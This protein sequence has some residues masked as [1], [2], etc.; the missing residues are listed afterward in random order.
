[1]NLIETGSPELPRAFSGA[2]KPR[3]PQTTRWAGCE[4]KLEL[5]QGDL[6][7]ESTDAIVNPVG[8]GL[9]D[10]AVRKAAG[11]E[12]LDAYHQAAA[13]LPAGRLLPGQS[14]LTPGFGLCA[15]HVIHTR[16]PVYA[17]DPARA[18]RELAAGY[19]SALRLG[20]THGFESI[21]FPAIATGVYRY[22]LGEAA[23]VAL[24]ALLAALREGAAPRTV[25]FVLSRRAALDAF[26]EAARRHLGGRLVSGERGPTFTGLHAA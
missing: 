5:V 21:A 7:H 23:D 17:D 19:Q 2:A 15:R 13:E 18:R 14:I 6:I 12:L 24:G 16:P 20:A 11:P 22:P 25:R 1:V 3:E 9:V 8:A 10:L 4:P 26:V